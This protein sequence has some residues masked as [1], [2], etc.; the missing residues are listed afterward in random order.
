MK[1]TRKVLFSQAFLIKR[2]RIFRASSAIRPP[3]SSIS[4]SLQPA[5]ESKMIKLNLFSKTNKGGANSVYLRK[6][7]FQRKF[8]RFDTMT[9]QK[10]LI[11]QKGHQISF[12]CFKITLLRKFRVISIFFVLSQCTFLKFYTFFKVQHIERRKTNQA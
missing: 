10:N 2:K 9:L 11:K 1:Q 4:T 8:S 12:S 5:V 3:K 6:C 7:L